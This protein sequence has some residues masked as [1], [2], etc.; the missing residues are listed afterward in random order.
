[1]WHC[2]CVW[3]HLEQVLTDVALCLC[4]W[5]HLEQVLTD[6]ALCLCVWM[7]FFLG[8]PAVL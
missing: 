3:M 5:M 4:V 2:L 6:V 7:R 8:L 1:M